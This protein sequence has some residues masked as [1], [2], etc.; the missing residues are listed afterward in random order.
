MHCNLLELLHL[1]FDNFINKKIRN[2]AIVGWRSAYDNEN[3]TDD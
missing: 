2:D 3:L 1:L